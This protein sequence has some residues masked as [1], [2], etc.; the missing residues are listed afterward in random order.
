MRSTT[1][2]ARDLCSCRSTPWSEKKELISDIWRK[3][4]ATYG[5][6]GVCALEL[7][8]IGGKPFQRERARITTR[9]I[10]ISP[11]EMR[12]SSG[13]RR[14]CRR[15]RAQRTL[16]C[17]GGRRRRKPLHIFFE[18][19]DASFERRRRGRRHRGTRGWRAGCGLLQGH[20]LH[21][22]GR[23]DRPEGGALWHPPL[24]EVQARDQLPSSQLPLHVGGNSP[25]PAPRPL[26]GMAVILVLLLCAAATASDLC[27][28][29]GSL[30]CTA[31]LAAV[32]LHPSSDT[33]NVQQHHR[34]PHWRDLPAVPPGNFSAVRL[35]ISERGKP[36][37]SR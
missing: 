18:H 25:A 2:L 29:L 34:H 27:H 14:G 22:G 1:T 28:H 19:G 4:G 5:G 32:L 23:L 10:R 3:R 21:G 6:K 26:R 36:D 24:R 33:T 8:V 30:L 16:D 20:R 15:G 11:R 35:C 7:P 17:R 13:G 12:I 9:E 31:A 37:R